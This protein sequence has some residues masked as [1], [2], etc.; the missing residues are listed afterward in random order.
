MISPIS[1]EGSHGTLT[2]LRLAGVAF[3]A[4]F[5]MAAEEELLWYSDLQ[6]A[7]GTGRYLITSDLAPGE[8][9]IT[10]VASDGAG[11]VTRSE[12]IARIPFAAHMVSQP[13]NTG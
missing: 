2:E 8:H 12:Y 11:A 3:S 10:L 5:G 7:L 6:G 9:R 4:D 1:N 13:L